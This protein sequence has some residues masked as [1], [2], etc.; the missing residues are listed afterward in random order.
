[1]SSSLRCRITGCDL[2]EC[3]VCRRCG[4]EAGAQHRWNEAERTRPCFHREVC[5]RCGAEKERP[6]HD[7][8]TVTGAMADVTG[9]RC[10]RCGLSI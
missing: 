9:L 2:D 1:M 7:W 5:E 8:A 4:A 6:D 10:S 3:G